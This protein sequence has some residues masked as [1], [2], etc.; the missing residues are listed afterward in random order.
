[1]TGF[2]RTQLQTAWGTLS[3]ELSSVNHR[4]QEITVRLPREFSSWEPWFHQ[5]L[6]GCFRRGKVQLRMEILWAS[7][8]K[9]A[10][11]DRDVMLSYCNELLN[12]QK[13]LGQ[14]QELQL[15]TIAS[16]PGVLTL[17]SLEEKGETDKIEG[18]FSE[19]LD[20]AVES[21]QK[22]RSLEGNHLRTE[23]LSHFSEL[24]NSL[25][26]IEQKWSIAR[27]SALELLRGR[28]SK[29]LSELNETMEESRFLQEI[30]ILTDKWDVAEE[31]ARIKSHIIKFKSTGEEA[32]SSGRKLDFIIQEIN[33]EVNTVNSKVA[34]AEIRWLAVEAKAAL[35]RIREQIQ[36]L[37]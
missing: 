18:I 15:E 10:R 2:S 20:K 21:W 8:F 12:I 37:E 4:Y 35:E 28:I 3:L 36:N 22:M 1:M 34:D 30:V 14:S 11:V 32:E 5:K 27:D 33:R 19:L 9:M 24:E 6:R 16:L 25:N 17:P 7:S 26:E 13:E 23:V 29:T 31:L